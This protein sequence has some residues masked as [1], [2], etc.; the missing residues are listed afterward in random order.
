M[1][2]LLE[3]PSRVRRAIGG[4]ILVGAVAL[5]AFTILERPLIGVGVYVVAIVGVVLVQ[6]RVQGPVF[7]ERDERISQ[8]AARWTLTLLGLTSA[9]V[10]PALTVAWGLDLFD[11]EPWSTAI[12]LFVAVLYVTY[13]G[14]NLVLSRRR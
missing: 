8:E 13:G 4:L 3:R 1:S 2:H 7:D 14:F 10:F 11:W 9:V 5:A 12:A 6:S